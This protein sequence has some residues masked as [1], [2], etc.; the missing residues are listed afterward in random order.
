LQLE[1]QLQQEELEKYSHYSQVVSVQN[2]EIDSH[3]QQINNVAVDS[4]LVPNEAAKSH[5]DAE[6]QFAL[7]KLVI[8]PWEEFVHNKH[9]IGLGYDKV[10]SFHIPDYS[11]P[12]QFQSAGFLQD[13]SS[14]LAPHDSSSS[15]VSDFGPLPQQP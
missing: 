8:R 7:P 14:S 4:D 6:I 10:V 1:S 2:I 9:K 12:I 11:K 13:G 5:A 15:I 3:K